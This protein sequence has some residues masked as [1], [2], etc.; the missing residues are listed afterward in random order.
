MT[1]YIKI[2]HEYDD[3]DGERNC[4]AMHIEVDGVRVKTY[5]RDDSGSYFE[6]RAEGY[7]DALCDQYPD[8]QWTY[9][10]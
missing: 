8:H 4:I 1:T 7:I 10:E 9:F 2:N 6:E 5:T 3:F